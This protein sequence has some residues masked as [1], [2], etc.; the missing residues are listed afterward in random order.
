M[1]ASPAGRPLSATSD[2]G[3][4]TA[5]LAGAGFVLLF[6]FYLVYHYG[7]SAGWWGAFAGGLFAPATALVASLAVASVVLRGGLASRPGLL[8]VLILALATHLVVWSLGH[9]PLVEHGAFGPQIL[10]ES[11]ATVVIWLAVLFVGTNLPTGGPAL[12]WVNAL[13][14]LAVGLSFGHAVYVGGFPAGPF[15]A[16]A[17]AEEGGFSTYQGIGRSLLAVGLVAALATRPFSLAAVCVL[18]GTSLLMLALGSRA[19]F[20]ALCLVVPLQMLITS[21]RPESRRLGLLS[22]TVT[23]A[24]A[25]ASVGLFLE[26]RAAEVIDLASSASWGDRSLANERALELIAEHP[27]T[28]AFGYHAL[29]PAG[30]AHNLLSAWTQYGLPGFLLYVATLL[31]A[32]LMSAAGY[33]RGRGS[34]AAWLLALQMNIVCLVLALASE[35][36]MSSVFPALAWGMTLRAERL[37]RAQALPRGA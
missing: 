30:Y 21:A 28:G 10:T 27:V 23:A 24:V 32:L 17:N 19:H 14:L 22:L 6:P 12:G 26:T 1:Q 25:A 5:R 20:F 37:A 18:L 31:V 36:I 4:V 16:F 7:L 33:R 15:L 35:P 13:G 8:Q 29:D 9:L 2:D 11:L 34:Q 3:G